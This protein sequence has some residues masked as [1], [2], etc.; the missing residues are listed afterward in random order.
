LL[1]ATST[2]IHRVFP[3]YFFSTEVSRYLF[4]DLALGVVVFHLRVIRLCGWTVVP[5]LL[6]RTS[7]GWTPYGEE[8]HEN[9]KRLAGAGWC[10][11]SNH[12]FSKGC[13][14]FTSKK[15]TQGIGDAQGGRALFHR[16]VESFC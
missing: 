11:D 1:A 5:L 6:A 9:A 3:G 14:S 16:G 7:S 2:H 10:I 4:I 13:F 15:V 8:A 12:D